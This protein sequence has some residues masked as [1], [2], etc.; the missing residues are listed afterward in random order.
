M[1]ECSKCKKSQPETN[2]QPVLWAVDG[3]QNQCKSCNKEVRLKKI[4]TIEGKLNQLFYSNKYKG[5]TKESFFNTFKNDAEF[6]RFFSEWKES[7]FDVKHS[8]S[9]DGVGWVK[10]GEFQIINNRSRTNKFQMAVICTEL[11]TGI[12]TEYCSAREC[13]RQKG[14]VNSSISKCC[15]GKMKSHRGHTFSFK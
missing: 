11:A 2:F 5:F 6:I 7:G 4:R 1:K 3:Y 14:F 9:F 8:P 10:Y 13:S 15:L 12:V